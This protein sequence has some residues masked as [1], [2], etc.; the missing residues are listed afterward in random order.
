MA[1]GVVD[2]WLCGRGGGSALKHTAGR[3]TPYCGGAE[4]AP[5]ARPEQPLGAPRGAHVSVETAATGVPAVQ[6]YA[7]AY[8][9]ADNGGPGETRPS[10]VAQSAPQ[11]GKVSAAG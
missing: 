7:A 5:Q 10:A 4:D 9:A 3:D 8:A 11:L 2:K 6:G 1:V